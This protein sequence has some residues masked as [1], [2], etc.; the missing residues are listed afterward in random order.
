V[1]P[2]STFCFLD[3]SRQLSSA[4]LPSGAP[5]DPSGS[6]DAAPFNSILAAYLVSSQPHSQLSQLIAGQ[7]QSAS[8]DA[9]TAESAASTNAP[10]VSDPASD[11]TKTVDTQI[12]GNLLPLPGQ[13][14]PAVNLKNLHI[15]QLASEPSADQTLSV[16]SKEVAD[17]VPTAQTASDNTSEDTQPQPEQSQPQQSTSLALANASALQAQGL[18]PVVTPQPAANTANTATLNAVAFTS[19]SHTSTT[20][21]GLT[22]DKS[23]APDATIKINVEP[24]GSPIYAGGAPVIAPADASG[25]QP[26]QLGTALRNTAP[27]AASTPSR[28]DPVTHG[29]GRKSSDTNA[30]NIQRNAASPAIQTA[31]AAAVPS[32]PVGGDTAVFAN[33]GLTPADLNLPD[34]ASV[35][36]A[37][38][39]APGNHVPGQTTQT[40]NAGIQGAVQYPES[41]A[42]SSK[43]PETTT[44][45]SQ[46]SAAVVFAAT[47]SDT[48]DTRQYDSNQT[49]TQAATEQ[50]QAAVKS[51]PTD[52][53]AFSQIQANTAHKVFVPDAP[54]LISQIV[55]KAKLEIG[56]DRKEIAIRLD[57]PE[58]G[59][60]FVKVASQ[61][62]VVT[63]QFEVS[64]TE[65]RDL[66][67]NNLDQLRSALE[68]NNIN[69]G[70]CQVSLGDGT[71]GNN[72]RE[73]LF[74][75]H[76]MRHLHGDTRNTSS[77]DVTTRHHT[78]ALRQD[79]RALDYFA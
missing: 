4:D 11:T 40:G 17:A 57:P 27:S 67:Q 1:T 51:A 28:V 32:A 18:A 45:T 79:G 37:M 44:I 6:G 2:A 69:V 66:L 20:T 49:D 62:G 52:T 8:S 64:N 56:K 50:I 47:A 68:K 42:A 48:Q 29:I 76:P 63:A 59:Q 10:A 72:T 70:Q 73:G 26:E 24:A 78:H 61:S 77:T 71:N 23:V 46:N 15:A 9:A 16:V 60:V 39:A 13:A 5:A 12:L 31:S 41:S 65:V 53:A 25:P 54:V 35:K 55:N 34:S 38:N 7:Q 74:Q 75:Q 43:A 33:T 30:M 14:N 19:T 58:L 21:D 3:T 36:Q 22:A